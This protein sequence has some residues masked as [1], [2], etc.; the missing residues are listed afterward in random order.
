MTMKVKVKK[1][2]RFKMPDFDDKDLAMILMAILG[3]G[4][5]FIFKDSQ[6]ITMVITGIAALATG[7]NKNEKL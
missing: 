2:Y 7:R 6:V 3:F 4:A 1:M 5:L